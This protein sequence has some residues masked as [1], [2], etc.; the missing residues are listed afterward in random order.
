M[1]TVTCLT[2]PQIK[3]GTPR[4]L[5]LTNLQ[6]TALV[7]RYLTR[8]KH[9]Q[10]IKCNKHVLNE[11][12]R[13]KRKW[14]WVFWCKNHWNQSYGCEDMVKQSYRGLLSF[15]EVDR[16]NLEFF[17]QIPGVWVQKSRPRVDFPRVQGPFYKI[18]KITWNNEL[19]YRGK[20]L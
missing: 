7:Q 18:T 1:F 10:S 2:D 19:F 16:V 6:R 5:G 12:I 17:F 13:W 3:A 4:R 20:I 9:H 14:F 8:S 15:L 11:C